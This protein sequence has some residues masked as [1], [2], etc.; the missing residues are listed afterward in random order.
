MSDLSWIF[1]GPIICSQLNSG[2]IIWGHRCMTTVCWGCAA[3]WMFS[4]YPPPKSAYMWFWKTFITR[5]N[6]VLQTVESK[7]H[8][9]EC[10]ESK[11]TILPDVKLWSSYM[12]C[13]LCCVSLEVTQQ[14]CFFW[15]NFAKSFYSLFCTIHTDQYSDPQSYPQTTP[16][17]LGQ[18]LLNTNGRDQT[19]VIQRAK[20][21]RL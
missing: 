1:W 2:S 19:E 9:Q 13:E 3:K 20:P 4:Q 8:T 6:I 16:P 7:L 11:T 5:S 18:L 15:M 17:P 14:F 21:W 10:K 12:C